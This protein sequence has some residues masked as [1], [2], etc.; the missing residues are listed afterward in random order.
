MSISLSLI[1][2]LKSEKR[3]LEICSQDIIY[4]VGKDLS[5][6]MFFVEKIYTETKSLAIGK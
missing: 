3:N 2:N 1:R 6:R 4:S 5:I